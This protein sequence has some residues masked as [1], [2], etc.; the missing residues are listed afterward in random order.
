[1]YIP[2]FSWVGAAEYGEYKFDKAVDAMKAMMK[3]RNVTLTPDYEKMMY[4]IFK[5]R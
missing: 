4:E 3:R 5:T 2:S 1:M